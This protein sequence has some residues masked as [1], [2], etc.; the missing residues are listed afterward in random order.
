MSVY[1]SLSIVFIVSGLISGSSCQL[2]SSLG[3]LG[4]QGAKG[5]P[6]APG[7]PGPTGAAGFSDGARL[8][9]I[10]LRSD[11]LLQTPV[12]IWDTRYG[13]ECKFGLFNGDIR[14]IPVGYKE[15]TGIV[16]SDNVCTQPRALV[17]N[18][19]GAC[20]DPKST[21]VGFLFIPGPPV[22]DCTGGLSGSLYK[23]GP[24]VTSETVYQKDTTGY[25]I[26]FTATSSQSLF[27]FTA[28]YNNP[29]DN[30]LAHASPNYSWP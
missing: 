28:P 2:P 8:R 18:Q 3:P 17:V 13:M 12:G 26:A 10:L 25:C 14:C 19:T 7:V 5:D 24:L 16:Y 23:K 9:H 11:D 22:A 29:E 15:A 20:D 6:G 27:D 30:N 1:R 21:N 4:P